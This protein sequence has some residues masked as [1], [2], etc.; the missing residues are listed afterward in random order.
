VSCS[1]WL[2]VHWCPILCLQRR[3][4]KVA[5]GL[6]C[7]WSW[8]RNNTAATHLQRAA[9]N[10]G[11]RRFVAW[12]SWTYTSWQVMQWDSDMLIGVSHVHLYFVKRNMSES[13][14]MLPQ[15]WKVHYLYECDQCAWVSNYTYA[16]FFS[17]SIKLHG[18]LE[19]VYASL[20][21]CVL[22]VKVSFWFLSEYWVQSCIC[23]GEFS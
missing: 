1:D 2:A 22:T 18:L 16:G 5:R 7:C 17:C 6:F 23:C 14:A 10:Y 3:V 9:L 4:A 21:K 12:D 8:L 19:Y 20:W 13:V 11:S 15:V